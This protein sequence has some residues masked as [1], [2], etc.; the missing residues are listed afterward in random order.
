[1]VSVLDSNVRVLGELE[2]T[3]PIINVTMLPGCQSGRSIIDCIK[4]DRSG[5]E[6]D[7]PFAHESLIVHRTFFSTILSEIFSPQN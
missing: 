1:M 6:T 4:D 7:I 2:F 3:P 5:V